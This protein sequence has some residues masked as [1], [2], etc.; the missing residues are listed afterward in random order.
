[1]LFFGD[2][3]NRFYYSHKSMSQSKRSSAPVALT[4]VKPKKKQ[5]VS[6]STKTDGATSQDKPASIKPVDATKATR[7]LVVDKEHREA[8]ARDLAEAWGL[9]KVDSDDEESAS[10]VSEDDE[11][12]KKAG[13]GATRTKVDVKSLEY[14]LERARQ[15]QKK[16]SMT[17]STELS[18]WNAIEDEDDDDVPSRSKSAS[19]KKKPRVTRLYD[20]PTGKV[21]HPAVI[22]AKQKKS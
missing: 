3:L 10:A 6:T 21:E 20:I 8:Q 5:Q 14:K 11:V 22:D 12:D 1:L 2:C 17:R 13:L 9:A 18:A 4:Q 7:V 19:S 16:D 15:K